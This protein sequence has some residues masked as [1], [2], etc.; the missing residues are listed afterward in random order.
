M[1]MCHTHMEMTSGLLNKAYMLK[2]V[3]ER[4]REITY[5]NL[6]ASRHTG[7]RFLKV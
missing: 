2:P 4:G 5:V 3:R 1:T 7:G 6:V